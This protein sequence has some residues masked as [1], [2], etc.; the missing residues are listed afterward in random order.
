MPSEIAERLI[1][2]AVSVQTDVSLLTARPRR[3]SRVGGRVGGYTCCSR[4]F[5]CRPG[6]S[7]IVATDNPSPAAARSPSIGREA[8][9]GGA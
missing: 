9:V 5:V 8:L 2:H 7:R 3:H 6:V 1:K 4:R